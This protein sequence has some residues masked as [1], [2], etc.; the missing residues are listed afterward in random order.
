MSRCIICDYSPGLP[1]LFNE[2]IKHSHKGNLTLVGFDYYCDECLSDIE[3][4]FEDY[5]EDD[6]EEHDSSET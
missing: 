5:V 3:T 6:G 2:S 4:T 1:S